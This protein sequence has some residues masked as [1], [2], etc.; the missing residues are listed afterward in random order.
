MLAYTMCLL[1][2]AITL[3]GKALVRYWNIDTSQ[4]EPSY[5]GWQEHAVPINM[6]ADTTAANTL[7]CLAEAA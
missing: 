4:C 5:C 6:A 1:C 3:S 2:D 7:C